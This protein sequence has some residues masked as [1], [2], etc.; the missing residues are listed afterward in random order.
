M[1]TSGKGEKKGIT[2]RCVNRERRTHRQIWTILYGINI[3]FNKG[4]ES[5]CFI[6]KGPNSLNHRNKEN[7][8]FIHK[9]TSKGERAR[10][11]GLFANTAQRRCFISIQKKAR[12]IPRLLVSPDNNILPQGLSPPY[13]FVPS[14]LVFQKQTNKTTHNAKGW[15]KQA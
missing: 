4:N 9:Y 15:G 10:A 14:S 1:Q 11:S 3:R 8:A 12:R 6:L 13:Y 5:K 2:R 7:E